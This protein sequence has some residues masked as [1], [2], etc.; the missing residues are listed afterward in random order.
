MTTD[1]ITIHQYH[2]GRI[3]DLQVVL[4]FEMMELQGAIGPAQLKKLPDIVTAQRKN[5]DLIWEAVSD[6]N[7]I[8]PREMLK[9]LM[10]RPMRLF[11][12][13]LLAQWHN[14]VGRNY[15]H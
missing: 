12:V 2:V 10:I 14:N 8:K 15:Y 11:S 4:I 3:R 7:E 9:I 13:C 5:R 1:M 6:I